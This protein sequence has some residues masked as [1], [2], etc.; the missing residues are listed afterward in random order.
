MKIYGKTFDSRYD[1]GFSE[2][3]KEYNGKVYWGAGQRGG[4]IF[5]VD[6]EVTSVKSRTADEIFF[7]VEDH[8]DGTDIDG[9][10]PWTE[11][12]VF[13]VVVQPDGEWKVGQ[14][15]LPY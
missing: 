5:Y 8:Y 3:F 11:Q 15:T 2:Y 13:S 10:A 1:D 9:T 4:N 14:F 12:R 7:T 6:S